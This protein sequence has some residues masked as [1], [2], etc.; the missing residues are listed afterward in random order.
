ML[1]TSYMRL[2]LTVIICLGCARMINVYLLIVCILHLSFPDHNFH[3]HILSYFSAPITVLLDIH[4][5]ARS[6]F[7]QSVL[8]PIIRL[9]CLFP[10]PGLSHW[11]RKIEFFG[12]IWRLSPSLWSG[13][14]QGTRCWWKVGSHLQKSSFRLAFLSVFLSPATLPTSRRQTRCSNTLAELQGEV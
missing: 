3:V 10:P 9:F 7:I 11:R 6:C 2:T 8:I 1:G 4:Q 14:S 13:L 5:F 12:K